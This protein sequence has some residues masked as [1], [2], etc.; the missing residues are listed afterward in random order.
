MG[1]IILP[2]SNSLL[3]TSADY[4]LVFH[5]KDEDQERQNHRI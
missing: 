3:Y 2:R 4:P 1:K 5:I